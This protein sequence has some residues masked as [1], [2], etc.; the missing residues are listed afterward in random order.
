MNLAHYTL[1]NLKDFSARVTDIPHLYT[2]AKSSW[3][4]S[5][6]VAIHHILGSAHAFFVTNRQVNRQVLRWQS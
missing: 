6:Y 2:D 1:A 5:A 3:I 4:V